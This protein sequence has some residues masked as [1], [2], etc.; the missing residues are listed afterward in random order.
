M[1]PWPST[2]RL[3]LDGYV[4]MSQL[5]MS[6]DMKMLRILEMIVHLT[7]RGVKSWVKRSLREETRTMQ[8]R[9]DGFEQRIN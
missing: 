2:S 1:A 8:A 6:K 5:L 4:L 9:F 3:V 7:E